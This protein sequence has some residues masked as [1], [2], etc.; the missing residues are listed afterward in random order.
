MIK[1]HAVVLVSNAVDPQNVVND[2]KQGL[3]PDFLWLKH[4]RVSEFSQ[5]KIVFYIEE[6]ERHDQ[7]II[8]KGVGQ[9]LKTMSSGERKKAL[10]NYLVN[11]DPEVLVVINPFDS[12]DSATQQNLKT[13]FEKLSDTISFIQITNRISDSLP[14]INRFFRFQENQLESYPDIESLKMASR[15][16]Q[17]HNDQRTPTPLK[18]IA[19]DQENLVKFNGVSVSFHGKRVLNGINW[20]IKK[21]EFWQLIGP[22]GSGKSTLLNLITGDSHKGYGQ[23]L[24][25][26]GHKKGSGESVWDLKESI[27]YFSPGM[28]DRFKGYHTLENMLISG[29]HDSVGLYIKPSE[30]ETQKADEWLHF[31]GLKE[32]KHDYFHELSI[33]AKRLIMT[34]RAMIKHPPLLILD[35][36]T[37]G[38]DDAATELF[39]RLVN[40]YARE[41]QSAIIYVSHRKEPHLKPK[42]HFE[43]RP[44]KNGSQGF[45]N[46]I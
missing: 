46:S 28:V 42:K 11:N 14:F 34:A 43:L 45:V 35:E 32:R 17:K 7:K 8:T 44:S 20:I 37:V 29:L 2:I 25:V 21:G 16:Q 10:L 27:G 9:S 23:D 1:T 18:S 4:K 36:P 33:G 39:V 19:V 38:L 5:A 41:S 3:H 24:T 13:E 22:N 31:L 26:F 12:L 40:D 6:E 30:T 15:P